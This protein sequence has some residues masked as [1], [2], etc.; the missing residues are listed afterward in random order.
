MK[1]LSLT[2]VF[3]VLAFGAAA[4][5]AAAAGP[6]FRC[7]ADPA[8]EALGTHQAGSEGWSGFLADC[9]VYGEAANKPGLPV[10]VP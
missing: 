1:R 4:M 7:S 3:S 2:L 10:R 9:R 8:G 5:P 6:S